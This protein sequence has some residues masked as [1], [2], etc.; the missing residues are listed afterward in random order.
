MLPQTTTLPQIS[1]EPFQMFTSAAWDCNGGVP[2]SSTDVNGNITHLFYVDPLWR[3]TEVDHP[4]GG[5]TKTAYNNTASP[6]NVNVQRLQDSSSDWVVTQTNVDGLGRPTQQQIL[7]DPAGTNHVDTT[8]DLGGRIASKSTPYRSTGDYTYGLTVYTYDA[9][10]RLTQVKNPDNSTITILP[11]GRAVETT[12]ERSVL[13]IQ[14][15]D[16]LGRLT[17]VCTGINASQQANGASVSAC[18]QDIPAN[19][20]LASYTY[21]FSSANCPSGSSLVVNYSGQLRCYIYDGLSRLTSETNPESGTATYSYDHAGQQGDLYQRTRLAPNQASGGAATA[22]TTYTYDPLHRLT[23]ISYTGGY[24]T[25]SVTSLYDVT[26][27]TWN[28]TGL[29]NLKG[30]L[31][32]AWSGTR[33]SNLFDYDK[34][35]RTLD[36]WQCTPQTSCNSTG[37]VHAIG[38]YDYIGDSTFI[39]VGQNDPIT[40]AY[41]TTPH[42]LHIN[43]PNNSNF[44]YMYNILYNGLEM[45]RN[46]NIG[47]G[48]QVTLQYDQFGG[49]TSASA[50]NG[51]STTYSLGVGYTLDHNVNSVN[52]SV[53]GIW[54]YTYSSA[55]PQRLSQSTCSVTSPAACPNGSTTESHSYSYDQF[56]NR[57]GQT[58]PN[59][60]PN[61]AYTFNG[62]NQIANMSV[63]YDAAG[64]MIADGPSLLYSGRTLGIT[65]PCGH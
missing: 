5:V 2:T 57:W 56:G 13:Q 37:S 42:V 3:P 36:E 65:R 41:D 21:N 20:F 23:G 61:F 45:I 11:I 14:Q 6:P 62:N 12:N 63:T 59:G 30:N 60:G 29:T 24:T 26:D 9:L 8:Y 50:L 40:Y 58:N 7:S 34:M 17:T 49:L 16:G 10:A 54:S 19:G 33:V 22:T 44:H 39:Q 4:D 18:G 53:N 51:S 43:D 35:G 46:E 28:V 64:N 27:P 32:S 48:N 15:Y 25:P 52:D 55:F 38:A 47:D 31:V 1:G